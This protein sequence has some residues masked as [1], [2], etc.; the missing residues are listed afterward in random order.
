LLVFDSGAASIKTRRPSLLFMGRHPW[1]SRSILC[2]LSN[3]LDWFFSSV[4]GSVRSWGPDGACSEL[5][6]VE[7]LDDRHVGSSRPH[8]DSSDLH[9]SI[10]NRLDEGRSGVC[11]F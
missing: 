7:T 5:W 8:S 1:V 4:F 10:L 6:M 2:C 9:G 3:F 11:A